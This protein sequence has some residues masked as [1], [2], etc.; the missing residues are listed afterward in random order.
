MGWSGSMEAGGMEAS[1][2]PSTSLSAAVKIYPSTF[3]DEGGVP[4]NILPFVLN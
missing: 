3:N 2:M 1:R 4:K